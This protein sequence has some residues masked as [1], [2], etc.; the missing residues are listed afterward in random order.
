MPTHLYVV[1]G[2]VHVKMRAELLRQGIY[3]SQKLRYL[4]PGPLLQKVCWTLVYI[5]F[6]GS[7]Q[8]LQEPEWLIKW[9]CHGATIPYPLDLWSSTNFNLP[10]QP[11]LLYWGMPI[12]NCKFGITRLICG[13][14]GPTVS[15]T[16]AMS[17]FITFLTGVHG[18]TVSLQVS[19]QVLKPCPIVLAVP[20][21]PGYICQ[22]RWPQVPVGEESEQSLHVY[23][24]WYCRVLPPGDQATSSVR[25]FWV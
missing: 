11:P 3:S 21:S 4:L 9:R 17:P 5:N 12:T 20:L 23:L 2:Y 1:C 19:A 8:F 14:D 18:S 25:G 16:M 13:P 10:C 6:S 7:I 24:L 15:Q 22:S